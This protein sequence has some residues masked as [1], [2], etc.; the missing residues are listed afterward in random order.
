MKIR[1]SVVGEQITLCMMWTCFLHVV[2][3]MWPG[4]KAELYFSLWVEWHVA[5]SNYTLYTRQYFH[6][7][8]MHVAVLPHIFM[9][10]KKFGA[11]L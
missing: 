11:I 2:R 7:Q 8:Q 3:N 5:T 10:F 9:D 1:P 6:L 4:N